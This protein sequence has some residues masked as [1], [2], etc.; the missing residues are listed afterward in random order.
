MMMFT[1]WICLD[2]S[3]AGQAIFWWEKAS[4]EKFFGGTKNFPD[5]AVHQNDGVHIHKI[6]W[7]CVH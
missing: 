4:F 3:I 2:V 1:A 6:V 5:G 7:V